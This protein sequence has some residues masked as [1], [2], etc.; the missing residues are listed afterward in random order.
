MARFVRL[1]AVRE[2]ATF[3]HEQSRDSLYRPSPDSERSLQCHLLVVRESFM[4]QFV[5]DQAE[6]SP[7]MKKLSE[8]EDNLVTFRKT[9]PLK[10][11]ASPCK[12][13]NTTNILRK[14]SVTN[15]VIDSNNQ[16]L[17]V[18][19]SGQIPVLG[20]GPKQT[21]SQKTIRLDRRS[22]RRSMRGSIKIKQTYDHL[23]ENGDGGT[24]NPTASR[25]P[26]DFDIKLLQQK[27]QQAEMKRLLFILYLNMNL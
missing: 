26:H 19:D 23:R 6:E 25:S 14:T 17:L 22:M 10:L 9:R 15:I 20:K 27:R 24:L 13:R 16:R 5:E 2:K 4:R 18:G 1:V 3:S 7:T 12:V 11:M 8:N 21:Q